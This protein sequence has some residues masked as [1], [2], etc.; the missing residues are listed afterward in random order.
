VIARPRP[1]PC[2]CTSTWHA[3]IA[4]GRGVW[5]TGAA[6]Q[7]STDPTA[8]AIDVLRQS[9][10]FGIATSNARACGGAAIAC[11][12]LQ[13]QRRTTHPGGRVHRHGV[14]AH[15]WTTEAGGERP[16]V[17]ALPRRTRMRA[18]VVR[19]SVRG[20]ACARRAPL[21]HACTS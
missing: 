12:Q 16:A 1:G 10:R 7:R 18:G 20:T 21:L 11:Q 14:H 13:W 9:I 19:R 3:W 2:K 15:R 8:G 6:R 4:V 5:S 17:L